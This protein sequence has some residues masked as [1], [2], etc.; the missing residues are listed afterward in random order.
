MGSSIYA[1]RRI[2][3]EVD[4]WEESVISPTY[5]NRESD[6]VAQARLVRS[7]LL[8]EVNFRFHFVLDSEFYVID[9]G[10]FH[11]INRVKGDYDTV[12][13]WNVR[14][15]DT[16]SW[17]YCVGK[18]I[19]IYGTLI[20]SEGDIPLISLPESDSSYSAPMSQVLS[21]SQELLVAFSERKGRLPVFYFC[22]R[23]DAFWQSQGGT[24]SLCYKDDN[25]TAHSVST[26]DYWSE[27]QELAKGINNE[28][29]DGEH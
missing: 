22:D 13:I 21:R 17:T 5:L 19:V 4:C 23:G 27:V 14:R 15:A 28:K 7:S 26:K 8:A 24:S 20:K 18:D 12:A 16:E 1:L 10:L 2:S 9:E 29:G 6:L 11:I 25:R 3:A